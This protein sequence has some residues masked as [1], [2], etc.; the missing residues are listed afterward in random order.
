MNPTMSLGLSRSIAVCLLASCTWGCQF[1]A[2][3]AEDYSSETKE[4][5]K[6]KKDDIRAC[7]EKVLET[8][9]EA[10]GIVAVDFKVQAKTGAVIEPK[11]NNEA[12][13][14]PEAVSACVLA[15]MDGLVL[16]PADAREGVASFNYEFEAKEPKQL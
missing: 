4:L 14:A 5:L 10:E 2:R 6:T 16:D 11:L 9:K 1:Y 12:T 3:S 7:Y 8:D 15:A 13:T